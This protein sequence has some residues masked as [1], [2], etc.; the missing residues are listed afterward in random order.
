ME[1]IKLAKQNYVL[2][3]ECFANEPRVETKG[4]YR[5]FRDKHS[6]ISTYIFKGT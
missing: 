2:H 5:A 6:R 4:L 1:V 3:T